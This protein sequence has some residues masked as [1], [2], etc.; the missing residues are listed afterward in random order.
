MTTTRVWIFFFCSNYKFSALSHNHVET[1]CCMI[2]SGPSRPPSPLLWHC[3]Y[4]CFIASVVFNCAG[5][6]P[7]DAPAECNHILYGDVDT[8]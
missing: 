6:H 7:T 8:T 2:Q 1:M 4:W 3:E 5:T